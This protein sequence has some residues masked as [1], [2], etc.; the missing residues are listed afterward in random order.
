M[1]TKTLGELKELLNKIGPS[2]DWLPIQFYDKGYQ[3][4]H[5]INQIEI[6]VN[7]AQFILASSGERLKGE[8]DVIEVIK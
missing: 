7:S 3:Q 1:P 8:I 4:Y 5:D 6:E 2:M